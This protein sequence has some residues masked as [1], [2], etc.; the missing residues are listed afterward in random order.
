MKSVVVYY[1]SFKLYVI[2]MWMKVFFKGVIFKK[3]SDFIKILKNKERKDW[4]FSL[5]KRVFF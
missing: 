2:G 5:L 1:S 4:L 3:V